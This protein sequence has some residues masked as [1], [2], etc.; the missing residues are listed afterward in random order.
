LASDKGIAAS[1]LKFPARLSLHR[2]DTRIGARHGPGMSE[3]SAAG[4]DS[5]QEGLADPSSPEAA[6][7]TVHAAAASP[8]PVLIAAPHAG[9]AYADE[10]VAAMR[11]PERAALRLEDR[12]VDRLAE[13]VAAAT[14]AALIVAHAPRAVLDLN[15]GPDDVDWE[16]IDTQGSPGRRRHPPGRRARSGLGLIPRRLPG[17]G[18]VWKRPLPQREL[19][20]RIANIHAPYHAQIGREL[21]RL[22]ARWGAALLLDFHSMPPLAPRHV[23]AGGG[24][25]EF[26]IGDRFGASCDGGLVAACFAH[27]TESRRRAAHNRPYAGG[28]ALERHAAPRRGYHAIQLEVDRRSYLEPELRE[29]GPGFAAT[30]V[31]LSGL[32]RRLAAEV[33]LLGGGAGW[34]VAAE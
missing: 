9:R 6:A 30:A 13:A 4:F 1:R 21:A 33:A 26:V 22:H 28:Y 11:E 10:V 12:L 5:A 18:E 2:F 19:E 23:E 20:A 32:V 27:F 24:A 14:G 17:L 7:F 31:L 29:L 3:R 16:M 8:I 34:P 15:R 25:A